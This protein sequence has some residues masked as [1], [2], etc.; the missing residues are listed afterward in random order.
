MK[1]LVVLGLIW[2]AIASHSASADVLY[3]SFGPGDSYIQNGALVISS[4]NGFGGHEWEQGFFFTVAGGDHYLISLEFAMG[5]LNGDNRV[6]LRLYDSVG[7]TPRNLLESVRV[8]GFDPFLKQTGH[9]VAMFRGTTVL[10]DGTEYFMTAVAFG[11]SFLGWNANDQGIRGVVLRVNDWPW[12]VTKERESP[13][14]RVNGTL[15]P[16]PA[17]LPAFI[18]GLL[19][20]RRRR[21]TPSCAEVAS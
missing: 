6:E 9:S 19:A 8:G 20:Q 1:C 4:G 12:Y 10:K 5:H 18:F 21:S 14:A 15:V 3:D 16:A 11:D 17:V 7:G 2:V 13:A